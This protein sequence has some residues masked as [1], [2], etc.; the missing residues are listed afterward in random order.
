MIN[1][2]KTFNIDLVF[3]YSY[4]RDSGDQIEYRF[5]WGRRVPGGSTLESPG[6][7]EKFPGLKLCA[8]I[9][10]EWHILGPI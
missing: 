1:S 3:S 10:Q 9:P 8:N 4:C 2:L 7:Q 5:A 6:G